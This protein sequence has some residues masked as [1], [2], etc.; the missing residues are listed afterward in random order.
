[1]KPLYKD[2]LISVLVF[3]PDIPIIEGLFNAVRNKSIYD[4]DFELY[5]FNKLIKD[6]ST[7]ETTELII[8]LD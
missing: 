7:E 1:M 2:K 4:V 3:N 8:F 6:F 5:I